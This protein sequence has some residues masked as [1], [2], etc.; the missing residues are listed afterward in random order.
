MDERTGLPT[1]QLTPVAV[2]ACQR[3]G[4]H[5][6]TVSEILKGGGGAGDHK[7]LK[8]IQKGVDNVNKRALS[9]AQKV[10]VCVCVCV[11]GWVCVWCVCVCVWVGGGVGCVGGCGVCVCV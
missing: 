10:G 2:A 6:L 7:V 8:M 1:D 9:R 3:V 5:S 4:S 11:G